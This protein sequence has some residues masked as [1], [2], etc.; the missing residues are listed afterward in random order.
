MIEE[1]LWEES[2]SV[3]HGPQPPEACRPLQH[4]GVRRTRPWLRG[5]GPRMCN[6]DGFGNRFLRRPEQVRFWIATSGLASKR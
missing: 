6:S 2:V 4:A 3:Y 1:G 5:K